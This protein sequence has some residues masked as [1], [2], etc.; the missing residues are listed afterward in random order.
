MA[1]PSLRLSLGLSTYHVCVMGA[2]MLIFDYF[3]G[4][5]AILFLASMAMA[6]AF[7]D[8]LKSVQMMDPDVIYPNGSLH[9][10]H[11]INVK[12]VESV[13]V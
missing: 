2:S 12:C 10:G 1:S 11:Q 3:A 5:H 8:Y 6:P 4:R 9:D 13:V 7:Y